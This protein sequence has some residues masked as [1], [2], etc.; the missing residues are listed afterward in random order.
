M[1][2]L[3]LMTSTLLPP[4]IIG[5]EKSLGSV[6]RC[7]PS[8]PHS[9]PLQRAENR[10]RGARNVA[11]RGR[12]WRSPL[13]GG[14]SNARGRRRPCRQPEFARAHCGAPAAALYTGGTVHSPALV[15]RGGC[16]HRTEWNG[17]SL[18]RI[19]PHR[20]LH[21]CWRIQ[22]CARLLRMTTV[23]ASWSRCPSVEI[24]AAAVD[25]WLMLRPG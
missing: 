24:C 25:G 3:W 12:E 9:Q 22:P 5:A 17:S 19:R 1:E 23:P 20:S 16:A 4:L 7:P 10:F 6:E 18:S 15:P 2:Y 11:I 14:P 8:V 13:S 21:P